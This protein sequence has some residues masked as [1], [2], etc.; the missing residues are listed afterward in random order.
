LGQAGNARF[1]EIAKRVNVQI[2]GKSATVGEQVGAGADGAHL[3]AQ[4]VYELRDFIQARSPQKPGESEYAIIIHV[5]LFIY[6]SRPFMHRT[7]FE[8][9]ETR[10]IMTRPHLSMKKRSGR[11]EPV[12]DRDE[13]REGRENQDEHQTRDYDI[14]R[15]LETA[16]DRFLER[17]V[18]KAKEAMVILRDHLERIAKPV[19]EIIMNDQTR[20][21]SD[22]AAQELFRIGGSV[23]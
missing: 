18:V 13:K 17:L 20:T 12:H 6:I 19:A 3:P 7:E 8:N 23:G 15:P 4:H 21:L 10:L 22:T 1:N 11:L 14:E 2:A 5:G 16:V 9:Q